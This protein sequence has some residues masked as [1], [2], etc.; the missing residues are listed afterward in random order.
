MCTHAYTHCPGACSHR[1]ALACL[2][3]CAHT[4]KSHVYAWMCASVC[5]LMHIQSSTHVT[6]THVNTHAVTHVRTLTHLLIHVLMRTVTH[7]SHT[8][9]RVS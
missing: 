8:K 9:L 3:I 6:V 1:R 7:S 4:C 2:L 5:L